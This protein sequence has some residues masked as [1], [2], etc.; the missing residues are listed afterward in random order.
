MPSFPW[1][2]QSI[3]ILLGL[4]DS[5]DE[6]SM[7]LWN[8]GSSL[9]TD[10]ALHYRR[11]EFIVCV[12]TRLLAGRSG[13]RILIGVRDFFFSKMSTPAVGPIQPPIEWVLGLKLLER[14]V[15]HSASSNAD[16]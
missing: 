3:V 2:M 7:F 1:V 16:V 14:E 4:L 6:G 15:N 5:K 10:M 8:T 13:A 9:P 11:T 12:V